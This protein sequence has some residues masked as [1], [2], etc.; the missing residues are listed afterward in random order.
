MEPARA[1][2]QSLLATLA[3]GLAGANLDAARV[4]AAVAQVSAAAAAVHDASADALNELHAVLTPPERGALVDKVEAHWAVWQKANAEDVG[5]ATP[6]GRSPRDAR[7]P[8]STSR[9]NQ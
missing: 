9:R 3:D 2:E 5:P 4:D 7:R 1:A 6:G 8:S